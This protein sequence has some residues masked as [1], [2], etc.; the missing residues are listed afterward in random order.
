MKKH[1]EFLLQLAAALVA[2]TVP[3]M[4]GVVNPTPEP[5]TVLLMGGGL[6]AVILIARRK[7][8]QK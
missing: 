2:A 4:A 7:R 3:V 1:A 5:A 6:A 8:A